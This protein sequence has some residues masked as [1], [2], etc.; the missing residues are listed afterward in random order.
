M[1]PGPTVDHSLTCLT[2]ALPPPR[3]SALG[4][5]ADGTARA[6]DRGLGGMQRVIS[7]A[8]WWC[9]ITRLRLGR[10]Q[11]QGSDDFD[12]LSPLPV[13]RTG[14]AF[15]PHASAPAVI[16]RWHCANLGSLP[17][18]DAI[19]SAQSFYIGLCKS[20]RMSLRRGNQATRFA[21]KNL[22]RCEIQGDVTT[23]AS[24]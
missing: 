22:V 1:G 13:P 3:E 24:E 4:S 9:Q 5:R 19:A 7:T 14:S 18:G 2:P 11:R 21:R 8:A 16:S 23:V 10:L 17:S 6:G 12:S 20:A 15:Q